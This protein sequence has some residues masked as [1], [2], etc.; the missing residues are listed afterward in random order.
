MSDTAGPEPAAPAD[1]AGRAGRPESGTRSSAEGRGRTGA[2]RAVPAPGVANPAPWGRCAHCERPLPEPTQG[3]GRPRKYC[4]DRPCKDDAARARRQGAE[5]RL[6]E[7]LREAIAMADRTAP[8][9]RELVGVATAV[10]QRLDAVDEGALRRLAEAEKDAAD[11]RAAAQ[12]AELRAAAAEAGSRKAGKEAAVA[13]EAR[14]AAERAAERARAD[15]A[16]Q[17]RQAWAKV[18]EHEAAR[19]QA[20]AL[21][22]AAEQRAAEAAV[23]L[24]AAETERADQATRLQERI[25]AQ[26]ALVAQLTELRAE[27]AVARA[28]ESTAAARA[29]AV[30]RAAAS[31][32][33]RAEAAER[34]AT[35]LEARLVRQTEQAAGVA[36]ALAENKGVLT[37]TQAQLARLT[38]DL[39]AALAET[40]RQRER[41]ATAEDRLAHAQRELAARGIA[42]D[43]PASSRKAP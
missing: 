26:A 31:G 22:Q 6:S 40:D 37:A 9:L 12:E 25:D 32:V 10:L 35:E 36:T 1:A 20:E 41:A 16:E 42:A 27:L 3:A 15:A 2:E 17:Q 29:D 38:E 18:A 34:R 4:A 23:R 33:T 28:A 7:P 24:R 43:P 14:R 5:Q 13:A 8:A 39:D 11:E 21:A 30:E 19:G